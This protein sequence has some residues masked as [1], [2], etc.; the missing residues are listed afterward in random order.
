MSKLSFYV[1]RGMPIQL[2]TSYLSNR[3]HVVTF[4]GAHSESRGC[5]V[6]CYSGFGA[7]SCFVSDSCK[8]PGMGTVFTVCRLIPTSYKRIG[9]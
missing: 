7:G 6:G 9:R 4:E 1:V 3:Q 5:L 2:L 8:R